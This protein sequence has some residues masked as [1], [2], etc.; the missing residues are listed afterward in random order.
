MSQTF[1]Q[2]C[3]DESAQKKK[4]K[5]IYSSPENVNKFFFKIYSYR[6]LIPKAMSVESKLHKTRASPGYVNTFCELSNIN[7]LTMMM[8]TVITIH[9]LLFFPT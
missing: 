4:M 1:L 2:K 6:K 3:M 8:T 7:V 5:I 9:H